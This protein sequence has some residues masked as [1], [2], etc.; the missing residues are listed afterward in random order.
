MNTVL[1]IARCFSLACSLLLLPSYAAEASYAQVEETLRLGLSGATPD[2]GHGAHSLSAHEYVLKV[3]ARGN[4]PHREVQALLMRITEDGLRAPSS[5]SGERA[6]NA[7]RGALVALADIAD[8]ATLDRLEA[9]V[10][11]G[12]P[13]FVTT[14]T[15]ALAH[16]ATREVPDELP[17]IA[18]RLKR[19][20]P[21]SALY[22]L[23]TSLLDYNLPIEPNERNRRIAAITEVF[24][25]ALLNAYH[26]DRIS[27]DK[28]L[29]KYDPVFRRSAE[30]RKKLTE[31]S[32]SENP[33]VKSYAES[34]LRVEFPNSASASPDSANK[35]LTVSKKAAPSATINSSDASL[36]EDSQSRWWKSPYAVVGGVIALG[37]LGWLLWKINPQR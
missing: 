24:K 20:R 26:S 18:R 22:G 27:L 36:H 2:Y 19:N 28:V 9:V 4:L 14:A 16:I 3:A 1:R 21:D 25:E 17:A 10:E 34:K 8:S 5:A 6:R 29:E 32:G 30:R 13:E 23:L 12:P 7:A 15:F 35:A 11:T 31:L 37:A 33:I